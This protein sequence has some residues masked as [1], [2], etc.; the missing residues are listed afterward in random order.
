[1]KSG[2]KFTRE[3]ISTGQTR[4]IVNESL[5]SRQPGFVTI[6]VTPNWKDGEC[7]VQLLCKTVDTRYVKD[8]WELKIE[9]VG[10]NG[11]IR[12]LRDHVKFDPRH[13]LNKAVKT[14]RGRTLVCALTL[15]GSIYSLLRGYF[16]RVTFRAL[17]AQG[18]GSWN[19]VIE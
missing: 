12:L 15:P 3:I 6:E 9:E 4:P 8:F 11:T 17:A 18:G 2:A 16:P 13:G 10:D 7:L 19:E 1:M 14:F 5:Q